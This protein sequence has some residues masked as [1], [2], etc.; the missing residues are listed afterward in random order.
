M[1]CRPFTCRV[2]FRKYRRTKLSPTFLTTLYI[3]SFLQTGNF[4]V[5]SKL[6]SGEGK[7]VFRPEGGEEKRELWDSILICCWLLLVML[8]EL[9]MSG[10]SVLG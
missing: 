3:L 8:L 5:C 6:S 1:S 10:D 7:Q 9:E 2:Q 4:G